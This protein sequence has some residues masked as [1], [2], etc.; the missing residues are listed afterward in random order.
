MTIPQLRNGLEEGH[1]RRKVSIRTI[2]VYASFFV[3][4]DFFL[5]SF[6]L[7]IYFPAI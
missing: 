3:A 4:A 1:G 2:S 6:G 5:L 7:F